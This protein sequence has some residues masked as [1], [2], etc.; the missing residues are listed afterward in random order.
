MISLLT[1]VFFMC[2][3]CE[4]AGEDAD[5]STITKVQLKEM[6]AGKRVH[7]FKILLILETFLSVCVD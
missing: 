2:C 7:S 3:G 4:Q 5:Y 6:F 1:V